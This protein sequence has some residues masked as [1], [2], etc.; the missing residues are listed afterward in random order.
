MQR[1]SAFKDAVS[2]SP[3]STPPQ[4]VRLIRRTACGELTLRETADRLDVSATMVLRLIGDDIISISQACK[5]APWA[6]PEAHL[7][8]LLNHNIG[9]LRPRTVDLN[10]NK[11]YIQ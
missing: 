8:E 2:L 4:A 11:L 3:Q 5:G 6:V 10:Q 7:A 9:T 1:N